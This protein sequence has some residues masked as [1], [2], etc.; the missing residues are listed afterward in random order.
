M[1]L[2]SLHGSKQRT[3]RLWRFAATLVLAA[4]TGAR[5][6]MAQPGLLPKDLAE[7]ATRLGCEPV[8]DHYSRSGMIDPPF[9]Y[10]VL[11]GP[12]EHSAAFWCVR[13]SQLSHRLVIVKGDSVVHDFEWW[14]SAHGLRTVYVRAIDLAEFVRVDNRNISAPARTVR[15]VRAIR[16]AEGGVMTYFVE[17]DGVWYFTV[18]H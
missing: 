10:G 9:T 5:P 4:V 14:S 1:L 8:P 12:E 2:K 11:E 7:V 17:V 15:D 3:A 6:A 18:Y 16:A 13:P